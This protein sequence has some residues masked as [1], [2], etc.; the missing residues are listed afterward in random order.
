[1]LEEGSGPSPTGYYRGSDKSRLHCSPSGGKLFARLDFSL[2]SE[3]AGVSKTIMYYTFAKASLYLFNAQV[4]NTMPMQ[5]AALWYSLVA[6]L[7][8]MNCPYPRPRMIPYPNPWER[9]GVTTFDDM[10]VDAKLYE[11]TGLTYLYVG[12]IWSYLYHPWL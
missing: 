4:V 3:E 5:K 10:T 9:G 6:S 8:S 1:M 11:A 2:I 7:V 12:S